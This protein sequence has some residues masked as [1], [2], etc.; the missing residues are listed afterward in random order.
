MLRNL[1]M[2]VAAIAAALLLTADAN[3]SFAAAA[4][5]NLTISATIGANCAITAQPLAAFAYDPVVAHKTSNFTNQLNSVQYTCT[6]G[7]TPISITTR[8]GRPCVRGHRWRLPGRLY[9]RSAGAPDAQRR[10]PALL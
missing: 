9:Q 10:E 6:S 5:N 7:T 3:K 4:S 2:V 8:P 1:K